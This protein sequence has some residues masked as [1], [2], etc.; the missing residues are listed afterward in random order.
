M[1][2]CVIG[3]SNTHQLEEELEPDLKWS[4]AVTEI[5]HTGKSDFQDVALVN[6]SRFGKVIGS[7]VAWR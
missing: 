7:L 5:L 2:N 1:T 3:T 6:T 4:M